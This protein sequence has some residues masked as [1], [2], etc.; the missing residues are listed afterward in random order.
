MAQREFYPKY[1]KKEKKVICDLLLSFLPFFFALKSVTVALLS[2]GGTHQLLFVCSLLV[3]ES[4]R[5]ESRVEVQM[6]CPQFEIKQIVC[7]ELLFL[8]VVR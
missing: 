6:W 1:K 2:S 7:F 4:F 8:N 3:M 5:S